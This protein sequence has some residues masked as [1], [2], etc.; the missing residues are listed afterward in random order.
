[1]EKDP[2]VLLYKIFQ[3]DRT[4]FE[5]MRKQLSKE[6]DQLEVEHLNAFLNYNQSIGNKVF[7]D[8][9]GTL[10]LT[11][12]HIRSYMNY[13][14]E[15]IMWYTDH[16]SL[17]DKLEA[18]KYKI[19]YKMPQDYVS[20]LRNA[21]SSKYAHHNSL[22]TCIISTNHTTGGNSGSPVLNSKGELMALNFDRSWESTMSDYH[23][24]P[25]ICRNISLT[26]NYLLFIIDQYANCQYIMRELTII[27]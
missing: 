23:Y 18:N 11:Y 22:K 3:K 24:E 2:L 17:L 10:R 1:M 5:V 8:A 21:S 27:R 25:A 12:G 15:K 16:M 7:P 9:N 19:E 26:A 4:I 20:L 13:N 14:H 6:I